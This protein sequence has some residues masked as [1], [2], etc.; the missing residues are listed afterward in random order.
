MDQHEAMKNGF[1][2]CGM[3]SPCEDAPIELALTGKAEESKNE[4]IGGVI[5]TALILAAICYCF[6]VAFT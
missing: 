2:T 4:W 3:P 5:T 1:C 6:T